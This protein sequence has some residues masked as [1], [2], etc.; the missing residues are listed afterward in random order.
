MNVNVNDESVNTHWNLISMWIRQISEYDSCISTQF[1][2]GKGIEPLSTATT[3]LVLIMW[4][5]SPKYQ[6]QIGA[7]III[8]VEFF[9]F[10]AMFVSLH[11][12]IYDLLMDL[13][14]SSYPHIYH[15]HIIIFPYLSHIT[16]LYNLSYF[17]PTIIHPIIL[18]HQYSYILSKIRF[19]MFHIISSVFRICFYLKFSTGKLVEEC[20]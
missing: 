5:G 9:I 20:N 2:N 8:F 10:I 12:H 13:S 16:Y 1:R 17:N 14:Y 3:H 4:I 15:I 19:I 6:L 18:T 11:S 7:I